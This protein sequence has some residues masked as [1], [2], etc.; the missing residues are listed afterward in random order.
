MF[1][2]TE[3]H[4]SPAQSKKDAVFKQ[5]MVPKVMD[6]I[7]RKVNPAEQILEICQLYHRNMFQ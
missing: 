1:H 3:I 2:L 7:T 6:L 5:S 4:Q